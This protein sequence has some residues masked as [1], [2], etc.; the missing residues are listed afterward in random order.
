MA[1]RKTARKAS[2]RGK[3]MSSSFILAVK[4]LKKLKA[5]ER[6]QAMSMANATFIRQFCEQLKKLRHAKLAPKKRKILQK[7][8]KLLQQL[9]NKRTSLSKRRRILTQSG[10]GFLKNILSYIPIVGTV[11]KIIDT[12]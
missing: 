8:K 6:S 1:R 11:M 4:R 2:R 7:N 10:G 3:A 5:S 9:V 12:V